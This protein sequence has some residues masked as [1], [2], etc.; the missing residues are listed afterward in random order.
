[1]ELLPRQNADLVVSVISV[2]ESSDG[3]ERLVRHVAQVLTD[4]YRYFEIVVVDNG[5]DAG[6]GAGL[7]DLS[8]DVPQL[9]VLRL[10]R[11]YDVEIAL[12]AGLD[13]SLGDFVVLI[14]PRCDPP[15]LIPTLLEHAR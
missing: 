11:R 13:S 14:D 15:E 7:F 5:S 1:M 10:S 4:S 9:R 8:Q 6:L 2:V 3:V 12:L